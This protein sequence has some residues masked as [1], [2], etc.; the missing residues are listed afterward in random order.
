M[1]ALW[2][3]YLNWLDNF[4]EFEQVELNNY[5]LLLYQN[6]AKIYLDEY[7]GQEEL[8]KEWFDKNTLYPIICQDDKRFPKYFKPLDEI[9]DNHFENRWLRRN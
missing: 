4:K 6:H 8:R 9:Q 2:K 5:W 3:G 7:S 1:I